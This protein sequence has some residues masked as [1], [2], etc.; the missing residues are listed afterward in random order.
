MSRLPDAHGQLLSQDYDWSPAASALKILTLIVVGDA[1]GVRTA[2]AVEFFER[3]GGG[4]RDAG[5]YRTG[6]SNARLTILPGTTHA[7]ILFSPVL[8]STV[9][10]FLDAPMPNAK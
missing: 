1:D 6:M 7:N 3:L 8:V 4:Q 2:Y 10:P 5:W 9:T